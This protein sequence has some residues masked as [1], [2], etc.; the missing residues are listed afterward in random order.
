MRTGIIPLLAAVALVAC[1]K[2]EHK[3][4]DRG[5]VEVTVQTVA[6]RDTP[7]SFEYVGQTQSSRQVQ[8]VARVS[9]FL[10]K[11]VYTEGSFVKAGQVM[12]QQDARPF[13][14]QVDAAKAALA[15]Q[16]ARQKVADDNL[17]RVKPL[18]ER[19]ALSQRELED[20]IGAA[21]SAAAAVEVAKAN[22]EQAKLNLS[23]TTITTP[24]SGLSSFSKVQDGQYVNVVDS[25]L[26]Y[27]A[28][29]DPM[30]VNFSV[31]ENDM[32]ALRSEQ[33]AGQLKLPPTGGFDVAVVLANGKTF[34]TKGRITFE[35]ADFNQQT[36]T[37]L[38]RATLANPEGLLRPGQFVRVQVSGAVRP[39]AI[40]VPQPSV[41]QGAQGHFVVVVDKENR[42][43]IR[44]VEVGPWHG[45]DWFILK[46]LAA[47]DVVVTD[48]MVRVSPGAPV[49]VVAASAAGKGEAKAMPA[50]GKSE[51]KA[52]PAA[53][54]AK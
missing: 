39:N 7:V 37:F 14:V 4:V 36:G 28:Q 6:A 46:G 41:L 10:D 9:G 22:L 42:A 18:A 13:Q 45:D 31:S 20:A 44:P 33:Q 2:S 17:A 5:P 23:Y 1:S 50:A 47:G 21:A 3:A 30:W 54:P 27:V 52:A 19:K 53:A 12:F 38:F 51:A 48:G 26:T 43:Q 35:S 25:Q 11:R 8:I 24:V 49:K 15:E 29:L 34:P 16:Q 40:L 32:L